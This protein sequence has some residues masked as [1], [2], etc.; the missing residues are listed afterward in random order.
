[1]FDGIDARLE[2]GSIDQEAGSW[3][4]VASAWVLVIV[5]LLVLAGAGALTALYGGSQSDRPLAGAVIPHHDPC[6]GPGLPTSSGANGCK[7][8]P[9]SGNWGTYS[10]FW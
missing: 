5:F 6:V 4:A 9:L 7:T 10:N 8:A 3:R 1:M 2:E